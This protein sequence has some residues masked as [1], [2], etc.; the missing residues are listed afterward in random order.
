MF[1]IPQIL[2]DVF[3]MHLISVS[4]MRSTT[5]PKCLFRCVDGCSITFD[6]LVVVS[7]LISFNFE[8]LC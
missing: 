5:I 2:D 4:D 7:C 6:T 8:G 3:N 1:F